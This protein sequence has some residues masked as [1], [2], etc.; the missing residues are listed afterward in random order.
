VDTSSGVPTWESVLEHQIN[1]PPCFLYSRFGRPRS[2]GNA[3]A[4]D[5]LSSGAGFGWCRSLEVG[6]REQRQAADGVGPCR[7]DKSLG[8][9]VKVG[10]MAAGAKKT[11]CAPTLVW[12][13]GGPFNSP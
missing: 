1:I 12:S 13:L 5:H 9:A 4:S 3:L 7:L 2:L 6:V 10:V 11:V 8:G